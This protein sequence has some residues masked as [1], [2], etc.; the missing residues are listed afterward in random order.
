M[1]L[2]DW[3]SE[4][5]PYIVFCFWM[6]RFSFIFVAYTNMFFFFVCFK[7]NDK[8]RQKI[9]FF[10]FKIT[11][12]L[13]NVRASYM[14]LDKR[15]QMVEFTTAWVND[16]G[17]RRISFSWKMGFWKSSIFL[18]FKKNKNSLLNHFRPDLYHIICHIMTFV[19][20]WSHLD[21]S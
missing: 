12:S 15:W 17:F 18:I 1:W 7:V 10:L 6:S 21:I 19:L 2:P 8:L 3:F 4:Y 5:D 13:A 9:F 20:I 11:I 16:Q 14:V